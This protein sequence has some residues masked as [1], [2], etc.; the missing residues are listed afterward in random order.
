MA[1]AER[2]KFDNKQQQQGMIG[3]GSQTPSLHHHHSMTTPVGSH[4]SQPPHSIAPHPGARPTLDRAHTFPTPPTSASSGVG[5][6]S[7]GSSYDTW[8]QNIGGG[9]QSTQPLAIDTHAH[10]TPNT[11]ATTPPGP[12]MQ[13]MQPYPSQQPYDS[14]RPMYSS[15]TTQQAQYAPQQGVQPQGM[16]R[17]SGPVVPN[18]YLKHEMG[19]PSS[20]APGSGP[21]IEHGDHKPEAYAHGPASDPVGHGAGDE[22]AEHEHDSEYPHDSNT[23][24]SASRGSYANYNSAPNLGSLQGEHPHLSPE[25]NGSPSHQNGSGR[26]TPRTATGGQSQWTPGYHTPPRAPPSSNQYNSISDTRASVSNGTSA[27]DTYASGPLPA[28]YAPLHVNGTASSNKRLREEDDPEHQ[29]RPAS[30]GEDID[31]LK[32]RKLGREGSVSGP[33]VANTFERDA[34]PLNRARNPVPQ[35]A[36]R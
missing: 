14:S 12:A 16:G 30:R 11:P 28:S 17:L 8:G 33:I 32:R 4:V 15:A 34:R 19:P 22:E 2:R 23:A 9:V 35:R 20:R 27:T 10:S 21:E 26:A 13:S 5:M 3:P 36:R 18:Q 25:M 6:N 29:S 7:Q 31:S 24:Y 1:A